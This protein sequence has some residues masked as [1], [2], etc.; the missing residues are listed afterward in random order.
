MI[1]S[2]TDH[3]QD[4]EGRPGAGQTTK[5]RKRQTKQDRVQ[6]GLERLQG[7]GQTTKR[8][9]R[10]KKQDGLQAGLERLQGAGQTTYRA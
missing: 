2:K 7:A 4:R 10:Q 1:G 9:K 8:R 6:T 5:R 3:K